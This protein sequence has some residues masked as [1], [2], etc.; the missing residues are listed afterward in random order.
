MGSCAL[1]SLPGWRTPSLFPPQNP[2][3][4]LHRHHREYHTLAPPLSDFAPARS[5]LPPEGRTALGTAGFTPRRT[6]EF[7]GRAAFMA[8]FVRQKTVALLGKR[9]SRLSLKYLLLNNSNYCLEILTLALM[10]V[11]GGAIEKGA[12]SFRVQFS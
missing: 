12:Q 11:G 3:L 6:E 1:G 4:N 9:K 10:V 7:S 8:R 2:S 5:L